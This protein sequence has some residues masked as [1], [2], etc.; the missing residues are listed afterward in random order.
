MN[1]DKLCS[2]INKNYIISEN[3]R[4]IELYGYMDIVIDDIN[5]RLNATFPTISEWKEYVME[6][7]MVHAS[8]ENFVPLEEAVYTAFP[9]RYL[10]SVVAVGAALNFFTND[11]EG[12]QVGTKYYIQ[13][14]KNMFNMVRDF[15]DL[16]PMEFRNE[17]G[18]Y[19]S[20]NYNG[21]ENPD[22]CIEGIVL[23]NGNYT[24]VL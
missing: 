6:Y 18:G 10:R 12:E 14:E 11:E 21:H 15:H 4:N 16:V 2:F 22:A 20:N 1:I 17:L 8:D 13:Y 19:I 7:N 9:A 3:L 5:D 23:N 24:D